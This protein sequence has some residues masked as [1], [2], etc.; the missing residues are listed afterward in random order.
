M[1][2]PLQLGQE[3]PPGPQVEVQMPGLAP[4]SG[5]VLLKALSQAAQTQVGRHS[6]RPSPVLQGTVSFLRCQAH[7][8][9]WLG[10]GS[11][12]PVSSWDLNPPGPLKPHR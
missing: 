3:P 8:G 9:S 2:F 12:S 11:S 10:K 7:S 1:T 5:A 6:R 4:H